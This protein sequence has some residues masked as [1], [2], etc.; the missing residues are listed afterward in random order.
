MQH[1]IPYLPVEGKTYSLFGKSETTEG[2]YQLIKELADSVLKKISNPEMVL[3]IMRKSGKKKRLLRKISF[4]KENTQIISFILH[5]L[6]DSLPDYTENVESHLRTLSVWKFSDRRLH[7]TREQYHLYMLEIELTNRIFA[8]DFKNSGK[9]IALLPYCLKDFK[10][11]CKSQPDD[12]DYRCGHCSKNCHENY[13]SLLLKHHNIDAYIWMGADLK[14]IAKAA[15]ESRTSPG[16]L[17]IACI[18]ELVWGMRKCAGYG[19]PVVGLPLDA[20]RCIR[21][22]GSFNPN[23]VNLE[24]LEKL[25]T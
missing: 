5:L 3:E 16:I 8:R 13:V 17:G 1:A 18:P 11:N 14:K 15:G 12:F 24:Q 19:I 22:M 21:W 23:S 7:T 25:V 4:K 6:N 9:K 20:N 10:V 2:Y